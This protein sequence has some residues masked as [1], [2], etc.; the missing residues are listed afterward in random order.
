VAYWDILGLGG[1][2][3]VVQRP[4]HFTD[5]RQLHVEQLPPGGVLRQRHLQEPEQGTIAS[6]LH[7]VLYS[8]Y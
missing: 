5:L 6:L 1:P 4:A 7:I 2:V 8:S 3:Q